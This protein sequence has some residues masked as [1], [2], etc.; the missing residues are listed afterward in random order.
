MPA[1]RKVALD[2]AFVDTVVGIWAEATSKGALAAQGQ[3]PDIARSWMAAVQEGRLAD[4]DVAVL[5]HLWLRTIGKAPPPPKG[6][7]Q[8][9]ASLARRGWSTPPPG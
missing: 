7:E 6:L 8:R 9:V 4:D 5:M 3:P 1:A 2:P